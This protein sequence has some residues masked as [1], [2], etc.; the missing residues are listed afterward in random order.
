MAD[1]IEVQR[2]MSVDLEFI[3][4]KEGDHAWL[5]LESSSV[6]ILV[7][8]YQLIA[9]ASEAHYPI[10]VHLQHQYI[11]DDLWQEEVQQHL[12]QTDVQGRIEILP[13]TFLASGRWVITCE[14]PEAVGTAATEH[15]IYTIQLQVLQQDADLDQEWEFNEAILTPQSL[16]QPM[17]PEDS[18][19][20]LTPIFTPCLNL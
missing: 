20:R 14:V 11:Q 12:L 2:V 5:P 18:W 15:R 7:G 13:P 6:E 19:P 16:P 3:I 17:G 10:N 1:W 8:R 4:Q 9:Q